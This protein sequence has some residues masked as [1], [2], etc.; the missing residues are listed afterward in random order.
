MCT[1]AWAKP[2]KRAAIRRPRSKVFAVPSRFILLRTT[3]AAQSWTL[4]LPTPNKNS[5]TPTSLLRKWFSLAGRFKKLLTDFY[6]IT[7][8]TQ[9]PDIGL[10]SRGIY[11]T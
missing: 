6:Y 3:T 9:D 10:R 11:Y 4:Y 1:I 7:R 8:D 2:T 5:H